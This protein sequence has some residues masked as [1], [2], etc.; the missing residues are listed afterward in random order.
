[1]TMLQCFLVLFTGL[2]TSAMAGEAC[3]NARIPLSVVQAD[4]N[5][6]NP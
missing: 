1:M 6:Y 4:F 3:M 2:A 5:K